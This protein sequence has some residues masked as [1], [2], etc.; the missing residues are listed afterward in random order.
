MEF[1]TLQSTVCCPGNKDCVGEHEMIMLRSS[2]L[3]DRMDDGMI[4]LALSHLMVGRASL[5]GNTILIE[6]GVR[7]KDAGIILSGTV[8]HL[9][10]EGE[11]KRSMGI[12]SQG[13]I[14]GV[15]ASWQGNVTADVTVRCST[16]CELLY[17]RL[18]HLLENRYSRCPVRARIIENLFEIVL[19]QN[20]A[21][22]ERIR[23]LTI[24]S[25]RERIMKYLSGAGK[26]YLW[27]DSG[28]PTRD[29]LAE[30][31]NVNRSALS[32]ELSRMS[33][34]GLIALKGRSIT[35]IR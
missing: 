2:A 32:R 12:F 8:E 9:C 33:H 22:L 19:D 1:S 25:L 17:L 11:N 16:D 24:D 23:I 21:Y 14:F 3:F 5:P 29:K 7:M 28:M 34:D 20:R 4:E 6:P 27:G 13:D 15:F 31:L 18:S 35:R 30:Y 10:G 26:K